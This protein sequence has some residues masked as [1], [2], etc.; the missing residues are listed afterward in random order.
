MTKVFCL[1][2]VLGLIALT[3]E[4]HLFGKGSANLR[5]FGVGRIGPIGKRSADDRRT[6]NRK[7]FADTA[8]L[9]SEIGRG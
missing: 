3:H 2:L 9:E 6:G 8:S 7:R 5:K 1:L 4:Q